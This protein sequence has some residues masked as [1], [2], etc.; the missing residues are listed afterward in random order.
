MATIRSV[1]TELDPSSLIV[2]V[3]CKSTSSVVAWEQEKSYCVPCDSL[4]EWVMKPFQVA[5]SY[6]LA[7]SSPV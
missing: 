7:D 5:V 4:A 2:V 6:T 1:Q 3:I